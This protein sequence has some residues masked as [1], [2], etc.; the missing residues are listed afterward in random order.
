MTYG[1]ITIIVKGRSIT[2]IVSSILQ[3]LSQSVFL[4]K[5]EMS[6][7]RNAHHAFLFLQQVDAAKSSVEMVAAI[8]VPSSAVR[9]DSY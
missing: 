8:R 3:T 7:P 6:D 5:I 1:S 4:L 9:G 2:I